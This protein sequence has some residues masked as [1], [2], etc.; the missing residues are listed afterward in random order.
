MST[1][2]ILG[3]LQRSRAVLPLFDARVPAGFPSPALDHMEHKLSLDALM[4]LQAPHTYVVAVSGDSM[5][6]AGIFDGDYLIVS[7]AIPA[8]PGH[9]VVAC[10]NGDVLV[11]RLAQKQG[12]YILQSENPNYSPRYILEQ[13]ELMIWGVVTHS[14]RNHLNHG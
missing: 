8:K 12:Q 6:G 14:L 7:R 5:S 11:K 9:V 2:L 1:A 13:D 3:P 4:D 10:L